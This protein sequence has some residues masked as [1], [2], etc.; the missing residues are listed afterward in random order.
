M[1]AE[2]GYNTPIISSDED[3]EIP[4][5]IQEAPRKSMLRK[6]KVTSEN[7]SSQQNKKPCSDGE[8]QVDPN[9]LSEMARVC[10]PW[11]ETKYSRPC[12]VARRLKSE[13]KFFG[14]RLEQSKQ[15]VLDLN[16]DQFKELMLSLVTGSL[17]TKR[18]RLFHEVIRAKK[19]FMESPVVSY[20]NIMFLA[21][22]FYIDF[23]MITK[24]KINQLKESLKEDFLIKEELENFI[25]FVI[26]PEVIIYF[27]KRNLGITKNAAEAIYL[28]RMIKIESLI[29][30]EFR[31]YQ[32]ILKAT[33]YNF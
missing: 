30:C 19:D 4:K 33:K 22:D 10:Q 27:L 21:D 8:H 13:Q 6:R 1:T 25:R 31:E 9:V 32:E 26:E 12:I 28:K 14:N 7:V 5:Q 20:S 23:Y 17:S 2:D 11:I 16:N 15:I 18:S 24:Q 3:E 29:T